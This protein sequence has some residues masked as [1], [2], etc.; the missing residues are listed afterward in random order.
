MWIVTSET[1]DVIGS[2]KHQIAVIYVIVK[3]SLDN[4][5]ESELQR[6]QRAKVV[7]SFSK[8]YRLL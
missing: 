3:F 1:D 8:V 5:S 6:Q 7:N 4:V 2:L